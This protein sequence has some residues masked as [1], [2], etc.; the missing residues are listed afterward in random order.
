MSKILGGWVFAPVLTLQSGSYLD[1]TYISDTTNGFLQGNQ[2]VNRSG[3]PNLSGGQRTLA[4]WFNTAVFSAPAPYTLGDAGR[5]NVLGPGLLACDLGVTRVDKFKE[6]F[7]A[8][9]GVQLFN[10]F[11]HPVPGNPDTTFGSTTFGVISSK[12][13]NRSIQLFGKLVF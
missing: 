4:Q 13:G 1:A 12:G 2:G 3:N 9:W 11:N 7:S 8:H 6:R 5:T 10:A